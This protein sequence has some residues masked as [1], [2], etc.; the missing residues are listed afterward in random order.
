M[1]IPLGAAHLPAD[2]IGAPRTLGSTAVGAG[3]LRRGGAALAARRGDA[4]AFPGT[5]GNA[6]EAFPPEASDLRPPRARGPDDVV[7]GRP[8]IL[9]ADD[10]ADMRHYVRRLLGERYDVEAVPDGEAALAAARARPPDLVLSDVMMPRLDGFGL[11]NA[12][13]AD[14]ATRTIPVILLSARAGEESRVEGL[15]AGADD[16]LV[17]PFSAREL[18]ARVGAHLEM[19]RVRREAA[20]RVTRASWRTSRRPGHRSTG[21]GA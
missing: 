1:T 21:S 8:R 11:L 6:R 16:Y 12:L 14:P 18:L 19:A 17:K 3:A 9:W 4:R 2:R 20:E 15:E 13:R 10:N 7:A 5:V